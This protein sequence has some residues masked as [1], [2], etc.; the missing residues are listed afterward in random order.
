LI[1]KV[2]EAALLACP[3][4]STEM[5]VVASI[6]DRSVIRKI[7]DHLRGLADG[8]PPPIAAPTAN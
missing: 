1:K 6:L 3:R 7:L 8:P 4:C 5:K 2:F